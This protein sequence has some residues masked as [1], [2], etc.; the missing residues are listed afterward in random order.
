L[1]SSAAAG[2]FGL[3]ALPLPARTPGYGPRLA[4]LATALIPALAPLGARLETALSCARLTGLVPAASIRWAQDRAYL[5]P[6]DRAWARAVGA[7]M[8]LAAPS[9]AAAASAIRLVSP[10]RRPG[11][12]GALALI[13]REDQT[14]PPPRGSTGATAKSC[15]SA[16]MLANSHLATWGAVRDVGL[17]PVSCWRFAAAGLNERASGVIQLIGAA[18]W[19]VYRRA[20]DGPAAPSS[21]LSQWAP[22]R[23]RAAGWLAVGSRRRC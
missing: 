21:P 14:A 19:A 17:V 5:D 2:A 15:D 22:R 13:V 23:S 4:A 1:S 20:A 9:N 11:H 10:V 6:A 16:T 8:A 18:G 12:G 7:P 3:P